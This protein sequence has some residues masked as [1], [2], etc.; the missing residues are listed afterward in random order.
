M[1]TLTTVR[2][3]RYRIDSTAL[4]DAPRGPLSR[5][6]RRTLLATAIRM[7]EEHDQLDDELARLAQTLRGGDVMMA[8]LQLAG[9]A[10]KLDRIMHR[11]ER[12]LAFLLRE[13]P[14]VPAPLGKVRSEH[15][16]LRGLVGSIANALDGSDV[17]RALELTGK[18]RSVLMV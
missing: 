17:R 1:R 12:A 3:W 16:S 11:E 7:Y 18:L 9:F 8:C 10:L 14:A 15:G 5:L 13:H 2:A 6:Q 4:A